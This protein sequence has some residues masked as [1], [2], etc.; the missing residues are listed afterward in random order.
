MLAKKMRNV[1]M[2][3]NEGFTLVELM[4]VLSIIAILAVVLVPKVGQMKDSVRDQGVISNVNSVRA[5]LELKVNSRETTVAAEVARLVGNGGLLKT[6][7]TGGNSIINPFTNGELIENWQ[8]SGSY[9]SPDYSVVVYGWNTT[10][11]ATTFEAN[12]NYDTTILNR[13]GKVFVWVTQDAYIIWG[14]DSDG[15]S[16]PY[17]IVK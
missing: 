8:T 14:M 15:N 17:Q 4:I 11:N 3:K 10:F 16:F 7:F 6:E 1:N 9:A 12:N 5:Y 13:K 2:K